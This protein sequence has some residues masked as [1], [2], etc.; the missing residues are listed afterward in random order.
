MRANGVRRAAER[1]ARRRCRLGKCRQCP[2]R[3]RS[4]NL[5]TL[6]VIHLYTQRLWVDG[7]KSPVSAHF[8]LHGITSERTESCSTTDMC[9]RA[10]RTDLENQ[11]F[12]DRAGLIP[13]AFSHTSSAICMICCRRAICLLL[14]KFREID[15]QSCRHESVIR[16][17]CA[18]Q[19]DALSDSHSF[20]P[21]RVPGS[22]MSFHLRH[23]RIGWYPNG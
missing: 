5:G 20:H 3:A 21:L 6:A 10:D 17:E 1:S 18:F 19:W 12:P 2:A 22:L 4:D 7:T 8:K 11:A 15:Q 13:L 9:A 16:P 23:P 14:A